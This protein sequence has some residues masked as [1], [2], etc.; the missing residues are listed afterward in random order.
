MIPNRPLDLAWNIPNVFEMLLLLWFPDRPIYESIWW[1][2]K[3]G[4]PPN[5]PVYFRI[6]PSPSSSWVPHENGHP[7]ME[8]PSWWHDFRI[9]HSKS[10]SWGTMAGART[11]ILRPVDPSLPW[12][13]GVQDFWSSSIF[14]RLKVAGFGGLE[15]CGSMEFGLTFH[16]V[17]IPIDELSMIFQRGRVQ[18]V[19]PPTRW[20]FHAM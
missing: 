15:P 16:L 19:Q 3:I 9:F 5:H 18:H 17:M 6:F 2:P 11:V 13:R 10:S 7:H 1:F 12:A 20:G 4:L 14:F 8:N